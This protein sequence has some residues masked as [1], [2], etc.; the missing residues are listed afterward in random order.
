MSNLR[1]EPPIDAIAIIG[2]SGRFP[3]AK[4]LGEFWQNLRDGVESVSFFSDGELEASGIDPALL[5]DPK[6]IKAKA[7]LDDAE[8]FDAAFFGVNPREA[9][10]IDPQHRV[11]LECAWEALE[12]AGYNPDAYGGSIGVYAGVSMNTYLTNNLLSNRALIE[13]VGS[14][15]IMLG[16]DKDFMPTRVS[17]KLNLKGPSVLVQTACSTSLVAV[18]LACQGLLNYQCD[19]ALAG[20]ASIRSPRKAGYPYHEGMILSPDGHC[21]TFDAKAQG[22]IAG[23][24]VGIVVLKRLSDALADRDSIHAVIRG[25]AVNNDGSL[26]VGYTA[27][28]VDGQA[29]VIAMAQAVSGVEAETINYIEAHGTATSMGDPIEIAALTK[30]FR[31]ST[32]RKSFCAIGSVKS[33]IG[34]LDAAAG[35]AGLIKTVLALKHRLLPPSLHFEAANPNIDFDNSPF[36]V[37][38]MLRDWK[39]NGTP[40]RAGVSSFGIGGTNAHIIVEEAPAMET[41][42]SSDRPQLVVLSA[43][44]SGSLGKQSEHLLQHLEE[45][46]NISLADMAYTL[47][48]GRKHFSHRQMLV[49]QNYDDAV[50]ALRTLDVKRVF[51]AVEAFNDRAVT[52]MFPGQGS[53]YVRMAL[54][55]YESEANFREQVDGCSELLKRLIGFDL[56]AV[57]YPGEEEVESATEKLNQTQFTQPALFVIEYALA[58]FWIRLGIRPRAMI[59]HSIG[60]YV[61]ACL[62]GVFSLEDALAV[63]VARGQLMQRMPAG[64]M[65]AV[66]LA[67]NQVRA[68]L[69]SQLSLAA[70]NGPSHCVVSGPQYA[71][72]ELKKELAPLGVS[73]QRLHTSHAFH[74]TMIAPVLEPF[75]EAVKRVELNPPQI[76]FVSNITGAWISASEA[77]DPRYWAKHMCQTVRFADGLQTLLQ[78]PEG[79]LLEVGPGRALTSLSRQHPDRTARHLLLSSL[80]HPQEAASDSAFLLDTLGRLWLAGKN[81]DW[82]GLYTSERRRRI[83]LPTYPFERRRYWI[84]PRRSL[85]GND[86]APLSLE[87]RPD[88]ADWFYIPSWK[89]TVLP[90]VDKLSAPQDQ[91]LHWLVFTNESE[92]AHR[93]T[94]RL[95]QRGQKVTKVIIGQRFTCIA[96]AFYTINPKTRDDYAALIKELSAQEQRPSRVVHLWSVTPKDHVPTGTTSLE[97]TQELGFYSLLFLTQALDAQQVT[98]PLQINIISNQMHEVFGEATTYPEKATLVGAGRAIA[99]EYANITCR[100]IDVSLEPTN[101]AE[102]EVVDQLLAEITQKPSEMVIAY[103]GRHR[104]VQTFEPVRLEHQDVCPTRLR[105]QGV[106]L[107]TGGLGGLG[108]VFAEYLAKAVSAK[109]ILMSRTA[110]PAKEDWRLWLETHDEQNGRSRKILKVKSLEDSGAEVLAI[111]ADVTNTEQM[112]QV[113]ARGIERFGAIHGVIHAAG[114]AESGA[115]SLKTTEMAAAVLAPKLKG[116]LVLSSVL[117]DIKPEFFMLCSSIATIL[118]PPG[119]VD[120]CAANAF[121]DAFAQRHDFHNGAHVVSVNWDT[122]QEVGMAVNTPVPLGLKKVREENLRT[123]ISPLEGVDAFNRIL[124][125]SLPQVI[126]STRDLRA[127][128]AQ[129]AQV[130]S[131]PEEEQPG[132]A[133]SAEPIPS[134]PRSNVANSYAAPETQVQQAIAETWQKLL[135]INQVGLFDNFFDL[136]GDSLLATRV[137]AQLEKNLGLRINRTELMFQT[138]G[139]LAAACQERI[140]QLR[141]PEPESLIQKLSHAIRN[142]V[143][144]RVDNGSGTSPAPSRANILPNKDI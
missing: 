63:V 80:R 9:E 17:Y 141:S 77:Q 30:A 109:L 78:E 110:F 115:I 62:A 71:L 65:M 74:S 28:S 54:G 43:K 25:G 99:Q 49:C 21:R 41:F 126:V 135:G 129:S 119:Q 2:M 10:I 7:V 46:P 33:N 3:G 51:S 42:D 131:T 125:T 105:E 38:A 53:Q 59:G 90:S 85:S 67:E 57:L 84:D 15:Q 58:Q 101:S 139:Q 143:S 76:P 96:E 94:T 32:D 138:L 19:I 27:P 79:I 97:E 70:L 118:P 123:G 140:D 39:T 87:K 23:E 45:N 92:I 89:R 137:I 69:G 106:Y 88:L 98:D 121:L 22:T 91:K 61:A 81:V 111:S 36:F 18:H 136:G 133:S 132:K 83:A 1:A 37:N 86:A 112:R 29:E 14:Y 66:S 35:V 72:V 142:A 44:T 13:S 11:F 95:E 103:R 48:L 64:G 102:D 107:I 52:F 47:Q 34:H 8:L 82:S 117:R 104:W 93:L 144:P 100:S 130:T 16:N 5:S 127:R 124:S 20:G 114:V 116:T 122:W 31:A 40:R 68:L 55:A 128:L 6:Y 120:Y 26:K 60:E 75:A 4:N 134:H 12:N 56:R 50:T 113:I 24:G 108:L 73:C